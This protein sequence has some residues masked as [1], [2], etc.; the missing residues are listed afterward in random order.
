MHIIKRNL[1]LFLILIISLISC[2]KESL[3]TK[4]LKI[5]LSN[6]INRGAI[7]TFSI[8][9]SF[10]GGYIFYI[11]GTGQ[12]GLI[13]SVKDLAGTY[14]WSAPGS[15]LDN[16]GALNDDGNLNTTTIINRYGNVPK[17]TKPYAAFAAKQYSNNGIKGWYLPSYTEMLKLNGPLNTPGINLNIGTT[18]QYL[19]S[20]EDPFNPD[21]KQVLYFAYQATYGTGRDIDAYAVRPIRKF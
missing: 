1:F 15:S 14:R 19:T 9:Q 8:G 3:Q 12:H 11:D 18:T 16:I 17:N 21:L 2:K 6:A 13:I 10:G 7:K 5:E 20:S 4:N